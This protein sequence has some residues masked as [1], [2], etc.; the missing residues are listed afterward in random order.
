MRKPSILYLIPAC[1]LILALLTGCAGNTVQNSSSAFRELDLS[2]G[3]LIEPMRE[4]QNAAARLA[5]RGVNDFAFRLSA[6]LATDVGTENFVCSPFSVWLPLAA[7][8]NATNDQ[9]RTDMMA[10]L[11]A[12]GISESELNNAASRMLYNLTLQDARQFAAEHNMQD[13]DPLKIA[14]AV[15]VDSN[16][17]LSRDFAQVFLDYYRGSVINVDF[18]RIEA[19]DAVNEWVSN[20]TEGL[21]PEI[22]AEFDPR[23][24]AAIAN[25]IYFSDRWEWEFDPDKTRED[26]FHSPLGDTTADYMLR[27]GDNQVYYEDERVQAIPLQFITGGGLYIILPKDGDA[28]GLLSS[29]TSEYF[30][31]IQD[32][33]IAATVR[34]MLPRFSVESGVMK[35]VDVLEELGVPLFDEAAAPLTGGLIEE[36]IPVWISEAV[37]RALIRVDEKGTTAAA[38]TFYAAAGAGMPQPTEPFEMICD[39]PFVFVLYSRTY[40]GGSQVLFTGVVNR[41]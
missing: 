3:E 41:P 13:H 24:V 23:T 31:E 38:V 27:E 26:V 19:V 39:R 28:T 32:D 33:S 18:S 7:L 8:V 5:A 2:A 21:I 17:T 25:A 6:A 30:Y 1:L 15:F 9:S 35:L 40:D 11:N 34:L 22:V 37:H 14:N 4:G 12:A 10:A 16:L 29:M 20:N 36:Q